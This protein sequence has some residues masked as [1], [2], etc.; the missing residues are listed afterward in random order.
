MC[1]N[2]DSITLKV[3]NRGTAI[4]QQVANQK[5]QVSL[6]LDV[7]NKPCM[8]TISDATI[9]VPADNTVFHSYSELGVSSN[10]PMKGYDTEGSSV[11]SF[12]RLRKLFNT[13]LTSF[14]VNNV[15]LPTKMEG[16]LS[17]ICPGGLPSDLVFERYLITTGQ[18]TAFV[19]DWY[20]SFTLTLDFFDQ[21]G[22]DHLN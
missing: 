1:P 8:V 7:I 20:I 16:N 17:F 5:Y 21:G 13:N 3:S 9:Q 19:G 14:Q 6:P 4:F 15:L 10:I 18:Q 11:N 2:K 22:S 12:T